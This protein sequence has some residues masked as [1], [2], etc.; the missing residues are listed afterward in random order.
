[1]LAT[2]FPYEYNG[3]RTTEVPS[4]LGCDIDKRSSKIKII[5]HMMDGGMV[6][7]EM[8]WFHDWDAFQLRK[9]NEPDLEEYEIGLCA[10][11]RNRW[12]TGSIFFRESAAGL[13][14]E[15]E[16]M[17]Y[18]LEDNEEV[19]LFNIDTV[20]R[21]KKL[22]IRYNIGIQRPVKDIA[23]C[24][25]DPVVFHFH[26]DKEHHIRKFRPLMD[27]RLLNLLEEHGYN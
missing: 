21:V 18:K 5:N 23:R 27:S 6:G 15:I 26:P 11:R 19:A 8:W 1:M 10:Y 12:N 22:D 17:V 7:D 16:E 24:D 3:V 4:S 2:D 20:G 25:G 13:F 14:K 9:F